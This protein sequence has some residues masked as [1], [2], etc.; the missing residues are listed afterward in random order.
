MINWN[1]TKEEHEV[2]D[3]IVKRANGN[4]ELS[5]DITATHLNGTP[6]KLQELLEAD[7]FN[8]FHDVNGIRNHIDRQTGELRGCFLPR[9]AQ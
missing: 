7:D 6:L 9:F 3:A 2:I 4:W 1:A 8:F 5:M